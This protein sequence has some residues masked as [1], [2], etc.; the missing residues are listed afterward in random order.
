[1]VV[2]D[3]YAALQARFSGRL[4]PDTPPEG[5]TLPFGIYHCIDAVPQYALTG[6][7]ITQGRYQVDV[8]ASTRRGA[9][10]IADQVQ[11]DMDAATVFRSIC[12]LRQE[13][14]EGE[15]GYYRTLLDFDVWQ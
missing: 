3:L 8:F 1:M 6:P 12:V 5:P 11:S 10:T 7:T 14:Y 15:T 9:N 2:D 13:L 4:Y